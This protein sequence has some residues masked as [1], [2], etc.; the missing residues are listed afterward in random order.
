MPIMSDNFSEHFDKLCNEYTEKLPSK[1]NAVQDAYDN[2][3]IEWNNINLR[4]LLSL[5]HKLNGSASIYGHTE[6]GNIAAR[7]EKV[8]LDYSYDTPADNIAMEEIQSAINNMQDYIDIKSTNK[9]FCILEKPTSNL[10]YL[11]N[12]KSDRNFSEEWQNDLTHKLEIYG[13]TVKIFK[14]TD[15]FF[16]EIKNQRPMTIIVNYDF[17]NNKFNINLNDP[18]V[19]SIIELYFKKVFTIAVA[20]S[21]DFKQRLDALRLGCKTFLSL[22]FSNDE[23]IVEID[24]IKSLWND[25]F[26]ALVIDDDE[27]VLKL[28]TSLL[29]QESIETKTLSSPMNIDDVIHEFSPDIIILDLNM[30]DCTGAEAA[31]VI[32]QQKNYEDIPIIFLS[33]EESR[34][35]QLD[36]LG[37]GADDFLNKSCPPEYLIQLIKNKASRY[38][39]KKLL[40]ER[41]ILT[42]AYTF[43]HIM[44]EIENH[45]KKFNK[46]NEP[47]ILC[48]TKIENIDKVNDA[49]GHN[50]SDSLLISLHNLLK[51]GLP[52][53]AVIGHYNSDH[54][55]IIIPITSSNVDIK[56]LMSSIQNKFASLLHYA[57]GKAFGSTFCYTS[58]VYDGKD[59]IK[60]LISNLARGQ[61]SQ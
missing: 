45:V 10:I 3:K 8:L 23:I 21:G 48:L 26:R 16:E 37:T 31:S 33:T 15:S 7:I 4:N 12:S 14:D 13:Y 17:I 18:N 32:R 6:L 19:R 42:N 47:F 55:L 25:T 41:D 46:T 28:Y 34:T 44:R 54:F 50:A 51:A 11:I 5:I 39:K 29:N 22:P 49:Y 61:V 40:Q 60:S 24:H 9:N 43:R 52:D 30:P 38:R 1:L 27:D 36:A 57:D 58:E 35:K 53:E 2:L 20:S 59:S 56:N